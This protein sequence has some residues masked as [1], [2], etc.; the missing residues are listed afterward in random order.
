VEFKK[1]PKYFSALLNDGHS[2]QDVNKMIVRHGNSCANAAKALGF[3]ADKKHLGRLIPSVFLN[4]DF[5]LGMFF[6]HL[7]IRLQNPIAKWILFSLTS[8]SLFAW[9]ARW[10]MM[11]YLKQKTLLDSQLNDLGVQNSINLG[12][13][14]R[15][16]MSRHET[17]NKIHGI[18]SSNMQRATET[19]HYMTISHEGLNRM[20]IRLL[21]AL[22]ELPSNS[23]CGDAE[24]KAQTIYG[25][26]RV[27][28]KK[29][30]TRPK[31][32]AAIEAALGDVP[33]EALGDGIKESFAESDLVEDRIKICSLNWGQKIV[34]DDSESEDAEGDE[35]LRRHTKNLSQVFPSSPDLMEPFAHDLEM[36]EPLHRASRLSQVSNQSMEMQEKASLE[37]PDFKAPQD[38]IEY[39]DY[40]R[41]LEI[42]FENDAELRPTL[43]DEPVNLFIVSHSKLI[44]GRYSFLTGSGKP[45]NN[46]ITLLKHKNFMIK[47]EAH[48]V[49][50]EKLPKAHERNREAYRFKDKSYHF[51][52]ASQRH[53]MS[54][55]VI[56]PQS[57]FTSKHMSYGHAHL[58]RCPKRLRFFGFFFG[59]IHLSLPKS[60]KWKFVYLFVIFAANFAVWYGIE[61]LI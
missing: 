28:L 26:F 33:N 30:N 59:T 13:I 14:L 9:L 23:C 20:K 2:V 39:S 34:S 60:T 48:I 3:E 27:Q 51:K 4:M 56:S 50:T 24:N 45:E 25:D 35:E 22:K 41:A 11:I 17:I 1:F 36:A 52:G 19:A 40:I 37:S 42:E 47:G 54:V 12:L 5:V 31:Q 7:R 10:I 16:M 8:L 58:Q 44:V 15:D 32:N 29:H 49:L 61:F 6:L 21:P 55:E 18:F 38:S 53:P 43:V 57:P 46:D